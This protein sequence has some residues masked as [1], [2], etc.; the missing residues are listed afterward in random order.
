MLAYQRSFDQWTVNPGQGQV[1]IGCSYF[2]HIFYANKNF[3][4]KSAFGHCTIL[5]WII[6]NDSG[7]VVWIKYAAFFLIF[8]EKRARKQDL[9]RLE[10]E[11]DAQI[12]MVEERL[13]S[14]VNLPTQHQLNWCKESKFKPSS[15]FLVDW[16][17][18]WSRISGEGATERTRNEAISGDS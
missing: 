1:L 17:E 14:E 2:A 15:S 10:K 13:R 12:Q 4:L 8:R 3:R 18:V 9:E 11:L 6:K 16:P 5:S 7:L